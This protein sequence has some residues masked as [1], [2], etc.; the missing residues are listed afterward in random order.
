ILAVLS[1]AP[2][3]A[4]PAAEDLNTAVRIGNVATVRFLVS[5]LNPPLAPH[6][7]VDK[8]VAELLISSTYSET[9]DELVGALLEPPAARLPL[10]DSVARSSVVFPGPVDPVRQL[11][12]TKPLQAALRQKASHTF[13]RLLSSGS[14][15][16]IGPNLGP[17]LPSACA[18][19]HL[20]VVRKIMQAMR[21][22]SAGAGPGASSLDPFLL[23]LNRA[24][25]A[26]ELEV[27]RELL[28]QIP[29]ALDAVLVSDMLQGTLWRSA[30]K[31]YLA[32]ALVVLDTGKLA[33]SVLVRW[34]DHNFLELGDSARESKVF[35]LGFDRTLEKSDKELALESNEL[36]VGDFSVGD[37]GTSNGFNSYVPL[38]VKI[39]AVLMVSAIGFGSHW[40]SEGETVLLDWL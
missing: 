8:G 17:L 6:R 16:A 29:P 10:P 14:F 18:L 23:G 28:S 39:A 3:N 21:S 34:R 13:E 1:V 26:G 32:V 12:D 38:Y 15:D 30:L 7:D 33:M 35:R 22:G 19:G 36:S 24:A 27:V 40:S 31:G 5:V 20:G 37:Q 11:N 4:R 9:V 25:E 2:W